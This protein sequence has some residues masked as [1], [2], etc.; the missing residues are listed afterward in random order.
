MNIQPDTEVRSI[1][2][3]HPATSRVFEHF[4]ID[5]YCDNG[6]TSLADACENLLISVDEVLRQLNEQKNLTTSVEHP[7]RLPFDPQTAPLAN[8][9]QH[10]VRGYHM[11]ARQE[12][13]RIQTL[14]EKVRRR[15][16]ASHPEVIEV[17]KI[18]RALSEDLHHHMHKEEQALFPSITGRH[19]MQ[20]GTIPVLGTS[21]GFAAPIHV[22]EAE[23]QACEDM[24]QRIRILT[25]MFLPPSEACPTFRAFYQGLAQFDRDTRE[26]LNV[27]NS[28]LFPRA[29]GQAPAI[30]RTG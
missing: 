23:H 5:Y 8:I 29:L 2:M 20:H 21:D 3:E 30:A 11:T 26:H 15:Y 7:A 1:A 22:M 9:I 13:P 6:H 25:K 16:G 17:E 28:F 4:G 27:E 24:R 19:R 18:F 14:A 10:I 12:I